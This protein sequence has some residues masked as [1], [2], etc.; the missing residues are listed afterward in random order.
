M[1]GEGEIFD[2][3]SVAYGRKMSKA[4]GLGRRGKYP[5][6]LAYGGGYSK[7]FSLAPSALAVSLFHIMLVGARKNTRS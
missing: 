1:G 7:I 4:R 6:I 5:E 3:T 2:C